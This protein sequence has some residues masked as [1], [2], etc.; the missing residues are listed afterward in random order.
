MKMGKEK[1][2]HHLLNKIYA[3]LQIQT[4]VDGHPV[5]AFF[6]IFLLFKNKH[7]LIEELL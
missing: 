2:M 6:P 5:N 7:V 3:G 4:K 1:N